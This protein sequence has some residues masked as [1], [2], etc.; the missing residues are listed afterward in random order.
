[1]KHAFVALSGAAAAFV[2]QTAPAQQNGNAVCDKWRHGTCVS[3]HGK[4]RDAA[5]LVTP[6]QG[7]SR[8]SSAQPSVSRNHSAQRTLKGKQQ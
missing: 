2:A 5:G 3:W 6:R 4:A 7:N 8:D 1:M